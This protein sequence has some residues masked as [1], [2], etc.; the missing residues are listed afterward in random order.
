MSQ[1]SKQLGWFIGASSWTQVWS[2]RLGLCFV[3]DTLL[4]PFHV[5]DFVNFISKIKWLDP[6]SN[7]IPRLSLIIISSQGFPH[8]FRL[9]AYGL[10]KIGP[11]NIQAHFLF[12]M[13]WVP[14][15]ALW[16]AYF[17]WLVPT[18]YIA[19]E[20]VIETSVGHTLFIL[21]TPKSF[22]HGPLVRTTPSCLVVESQK[23]LDWLFPQI[24]EVRWLLWLLGEVDLSVASLKFLQL[25]IQCAFSL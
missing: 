21:T 20:D 8:F 16:D 3:N 24:V 17:L 5:Q 1:L 12:I 10:K 15:G 2:I 14:N 23:I 18:L 4:P 19:G 13:E 11:A 25:F 22:I 7:L 9:G 6:L